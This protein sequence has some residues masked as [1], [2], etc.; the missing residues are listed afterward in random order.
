MSRDPSFIGSSK[1]NVW[2]GSGAVKGSVAK[3]DVSLI[4]NRVQKKRDKKVSKK[5]IRKDETVKRKT[6]S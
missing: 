5:K 6:I 4:S 2:G 1:V 3:G